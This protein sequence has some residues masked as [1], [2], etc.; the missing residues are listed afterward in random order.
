MEGSSS[1]FISVIIVGAGNFGAATALSLAK[2]GF[3]VSLVD[4]VQYPSPRAASCDINKIVRDDYP[5]ELYM[6]MMLKAMPLWR[7][8]PLYRPWYYETGLL[9]AGPSAFWEDSIE[10]YRICGINNACEILPI[11]EVRKRW[12]RVFATADFEGVD[13]VLYNPSVGIAEADK[14]LKAVAQ[15]AV[16]VG[17]E[18]VIGEM[19]ELQFGPLGEC[20]GILLSSGK[21]LMA[22]RVLMATGARTA[23]LLAKSAPDNKLLHA[24]DRTFAAGAVS[25]CAK[26]SGELREKFR[27]IPA[28]IKCLG[29]TKGDGMSIL[30]DG[31][32]KLNCDLCFTNNVDFAPTGEKLSVPL[33][34]YDT[35]SALDPH[36]IQYFEELAATTFR[37]LYGKEVSGVSVTTYRICWDACTP[38]KDFLISAHPHCK[39]LYVATGGS[40]HG[41]KFLPVIG[42]YIASLM[43]GT[44]ADD[45]VLRWAWDKVGGDG[46]CAN[47]SYDI[48]GD[49][50]EYLQRG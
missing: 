15:A 36:F 11:E 24:G 31:T 50:Q 25:F 47:A 16:D 22:D 34:E 29:V 12:N 21:I 48:A 42:E 8:D 27:G 28:L 13:K 20:V 38:T 26:L 35:W 6:R 19:D 2:K 17:V 14:A 40:F 43:Q 37:G 4:I 41:W 32:L 30:A 10:S 9:R 7:N 45:Y 46:H 33:E 23:P 44:L 3:R 1:Q 49:L 5:D 39:N 18:Y